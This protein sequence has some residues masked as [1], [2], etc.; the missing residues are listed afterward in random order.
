MTLYHP[1]K[2][3][4]PGP[5]TLIPLMQRPDEL[6][7]ISGFLYRPQTQPKPD[8]PIL[9]HFY[10][11]PGIGKSVFLAQA[12]R[13]LHPNP[14]QT[15]DLRRTF[16]DVEVLFQHPHTVT[17]IRGD[18]LKFMP[19]QPLAV[20]LDRADR[21]GPGGS[22]EFTLY[23]R[24]QLFSPLHRRFQRAVFVLAS[25]NQELMNPGNPCN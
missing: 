2:V 25:R 3:W 15:A 4:R 16:L 24:D 10:G 9:L 13:A 20:T 7:F 22:R 12:T 1:E 6:R 14:T 21:L 23:L 11:P 8:E 19:N 17:A 18:L 5:D